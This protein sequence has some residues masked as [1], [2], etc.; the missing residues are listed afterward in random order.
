MKVFPTLV[1]LRHRPDAGQ[2]GGSWWRGEDAA[3]HPG[4]QHA[5][6]DVSSTEW[7]VAGAA[8]RDEA[9]LPALYL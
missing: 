5:R 8:S 6:P 2:D 7:L 4:S 1:V 9:D 3:R